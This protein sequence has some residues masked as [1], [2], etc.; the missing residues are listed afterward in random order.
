MSQTAFGN[1]LADRQVIRAGM[2]GQGK[3]MRAG[4][5]LKTSAEL[6]ADREGYSPGGSSATPFDPDLSAYGYTGD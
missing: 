3:V 2:N 4:A 6:A 1:A 5:R